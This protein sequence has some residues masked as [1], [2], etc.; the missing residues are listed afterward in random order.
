[1]NFFLSGLVEIP[2]YIACPFIIQRF[3]RR[4]PV[5][6]FHVVGGLACI[7]T[8][9]IPPVTDNGADLTSLILTT[10]LVGKFGITASYAI[11]F[12]YTTEL[13]PTVIR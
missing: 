2:A 12:L 5:C 6:I 4:S 8:A 11:V 7:A 3:G 9:F 10:A 1:M 13:Y